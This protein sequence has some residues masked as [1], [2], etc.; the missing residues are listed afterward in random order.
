[1][2]YAVTLQRTFKALQGLKSPIRDGKKLAPL[3]PTDGYQ[4][5]LRV[6]IAFADG[7]LG[8]RGWFVDTDSL[9]DI[10]DATVAELSHKWTERFDFRP[11]FELVTR[12]AYQHLAT[13]I[14][15]LSFVEIHNQTLGI[16]VR[17]H[18][19]PTNG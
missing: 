4:L 7:Q 12:W 18:K 19:E 15:Q 14:Q 16:T 13:Q 2:S 10:L 1:M 6:G 8:D 9:D 17:Y 3:Q 5:T 11:T